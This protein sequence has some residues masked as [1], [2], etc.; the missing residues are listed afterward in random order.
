MYRNIDED[1]RLLIMARRY[2]DEEDQLTET[3]L[4]W[5]KK[6]KDIQPKRL[7]MRSVIIGLFIYSLT[8]FFI[9]GLHQLF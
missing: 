2:W 3:Q 4:Y 6:M 1:E 7:T 9:I 5:V 8:Y